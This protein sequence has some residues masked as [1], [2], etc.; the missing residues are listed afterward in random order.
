[1]LLKKFARMQVENFPGSDPV[2]ALRLLVTRPHDD[3]EAFGS[4]LRARGHEPVIAPLLE[5]RRTGSDAIN[6]TGIAALLATSA[7]GIR[8]FAARS[9]E[10]TLRVYSVGPQ[11]A[12]MARAIGFTDV[13]SADG[14]WEALARTVIKSADPGKIRLLHVAGVEAAGRLA[15]ELRSS[16]FQVDTLILYEAVPVESLPHEA[17][18][19]LRD[20]MLDGVLLF[21]PRTARTFAALVGKA[22]L[23]SHCE[24]ITAFCI[25]AATAA[26]L[27]TVRFARVEIATRP[28]QGAMLDL[29]ARRGS[30]K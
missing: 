17:E 22:A 4:L 5:L 8:F 15:E 30:G 10:R 23:L 2:A 6:T 24:R 12:Q 7:N 27:A 16:G 25:S 13:V 29:V 1:M 18:T 14:D 3:A 28:N 11:T 19:S 21:S 26:R 9:P 20:D